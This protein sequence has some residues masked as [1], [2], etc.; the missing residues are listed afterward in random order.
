MTTDA[1]GSL[2]FKILGP[3]EAW[4][5]E[6]RLQLKG[7]IQQR[8]LAALLLDSGR[9]LPV[10]RLVEAAWEEEPPATAAHQVRKAVADLR[11]HIPQ[12]DRVLLTDG[13]GYTAAL[14]SFSLDVNEFEQRVLDART[15]TARGNQREAVRILGSALALWRGPALSGLGGHVVQAAAA[16]LNERHVAAVERYFGLRLAL[17]ESGELVSELRA[18]VGL[19]PLQESLRGQLML[20]LSRSG[21]RAE[22]LEEYTRVRKQLAAELG[23]APGPRLGEIY[24]RILHEESPTP[25]GSR[26]ATGPRTA[27]RP[28]VVGVPRSV[29]RD[30]SDFVGREDELRHLVELASKGRQTTGLVAIDGMGGIG[31]TSL[32]VRAAHRLAPDYPDGQLYI[33][34][35]GYTPGE[36]PV[37]AA[38][39][40]KSLLRSIGTPDD[41]IPEDAVGCAAL[42]QSAFVGRRILILLDNAADASVVSQLLPTSPGC[43]VLITSRSRLVDLD[44][45]QWLSLDVMAP[46]ESEKLIAA[47][48]GSP[49]SGVDSLA[50]AE[51]A[52]LCGH[53]P[54]ALRIAA[55][56]LRNRPHWSLRY[57]VDRLRDE[58]RKLDELSSSERGVATT[59]QLSYQVLSA[60]EQD[61]FR[62]LALH[63]GPDIDVHSVAAL[64]ATSLREAEDQLERLLD[65]RLVEQAKADRYSFHDLLRSFA[66]GLPGR[67]S[68][69]STESVERLLEYYLTA[70][71]AA[72]D[73]LFPGRTLRP[74]GIRHS[75]APLPS[76]DQVETARAW[77]ALECSTLASVVT[78]AAAD[79]FHRH[80]VCLGRNTAFYLNSQGHLEEFAEISRT[81]VAAARVLH[82]PALLGASLSNLGVACWKLGLHGE[83][84]AATRE[85]LELAVSVGD[86]HTQAHCEGT[87]GLYE[88]LLGRF[89]EALAHLEGAVATERE[90]G[91]TR[92]EVES[93]TVLSAL[94]EQWGRYEE[95]ADAAHRAVDLVRQLGQ[96]ETAL[97]AFTD[98]ALAQLGLGDYAAAKQ[99]LTEARRLCDS[100][101]EP[102]QIAMT[103]AASAIVSLHLGEGPQAALYA[104]QAQFLIETSPSPLRQAKVENL[105]GSLLL[106]RGRPGAAFRLHTR[107]HEH[108]LRVTYRVEEAYALA[109]MARAAGYLGDAVGAQDYR[110]AAQTLFAALGVRVDRDH[111]APVRRALHAVSEPAG[112]RVGER[113]P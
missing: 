88:S 77:F 41:R 76:L 91:A 52:R 15:A 24:E 32:A 48:L 51:M 109:G 107:A 111:D 33:D 69:A 39:A 90:L 80:A 12:G 38:M 96:H 65:V 17:G 43:L 25:A 83:G 75:T 8:V 71:E 102:G 29:P 53:L 31:K 92:A 103:L 49:T 21:R 22:A 101:K 112:G 108:A 19:H 47:V 26:P 6:T 42:L 4:S 87:L 67:R 99:S 59:L 23:I 46:E 10:S 105:L 106:K 3:L 30:L 64:L 50:A 16:V 93:L 18:Y 40:L 89:P 95:A 57:M 37:G 61:A 60:K 58:D 13:P 56:R 62:L 81:S 54:L 85:G 84:I 44:G 14:P 9:M 82:D 34:L 72:C 7:Q 79:G 104:D 100:A 1:L 70:T 97:V 2:H 68:P 86:K 63:P 55:A 28:T 73:L 11:H 35:R 27:S 5:G 98:L 94:N 78:M 66:R 20:A 45:A 110:A 74:T 36:R 113:R